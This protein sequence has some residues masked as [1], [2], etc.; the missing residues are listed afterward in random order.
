MA[1]TDV[2][3]ELTGKDG[4]AFSI[5][6]AVTKELKK[7]GYKQDF[8]DQYR[9]EATSGDYDNLLRVTMEYVNVH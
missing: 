9:S 1:K 8:I 7:S 5:M 2:I 3:V 4:N 6:G